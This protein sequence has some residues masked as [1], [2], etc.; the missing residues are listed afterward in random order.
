MTIYERMKQRRRELGLTQTQLARAVGLHGPHAKQTISKLERGMTK[1]VPPDL[2]DKIA[3]ALDTNMPT[4]LQGR[5]TSGLEESPVQ[6]FGGAPALLDDDVIP[7]YGYSAE[8]ARQIIGQKSRPAQLR[9]VRHGYALYA[10]DDSM[11][12]RYA[13]GWLLYVDPSR[14]AGIGRDV[15]VLRRQAPPLVRQL[16]GT[17]ENTFIFRTFTRR[18]TMTIAA[19]E[20]REVHL[21]IGS[22]PEG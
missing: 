16:V 12:P 7:L 13:A 20:I 18:S 5:E 1:R 10:P 14:P 2:L 9:G 21:I 4:L 15:V 17:D 22:F 3:S 6:N 19:G 11:L 8:G